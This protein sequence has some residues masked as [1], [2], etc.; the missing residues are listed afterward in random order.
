MVQIH[1]E[2]LDTPLLVVGDL[3]AAASSDDR[4]SNELTTY[5]RE[6]DALTNVLTRLSL[7]DIHR[8]KFPPSRHY[9]TWSNSRGHK[10]R[11]GAVYANTQALEMTGG[12][13]NI[14]SSIGHTPGPLGADHSPVF[15]RFRSPIATQSDGSLPIAFPPPR[16]APARWGL[17]DKGAEAYHD[18]LLQ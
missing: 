14:K 1:H 12:V 16:A 3:N 15:A 5:D 9:Y 13:H 10:S 8:H 2:Y 17:D 7:I 18:L 11:I 4:G 6:A